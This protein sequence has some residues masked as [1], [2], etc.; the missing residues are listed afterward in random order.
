MVLFVGKHGVKDFESWK[1]GT[2][3]ALSDP[4]RNAEW[5]IL[6]SGTYR[7]VDGNVIVTHKFATVEAAKKYK[8]MM[9]SAENKAFRDQIGIVE[10]FTMWIAEEF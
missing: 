9:E 3:A 10:P 1:S 5:G 4:K 6:E 7:A 8:A 2:K